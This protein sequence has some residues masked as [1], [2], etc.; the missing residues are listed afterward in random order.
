MVERVL[1]DLC[2]EREVGE[3]LRGSLECRGSRGSKAISSQAG[4]SRVE[5]KG[6]DVGCERV[7]AMHSGPLTVAS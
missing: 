3:R 7:E 2:I 1:L 5:D 4:A 6:R